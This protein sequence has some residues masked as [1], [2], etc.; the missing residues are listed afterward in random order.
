MADDGGCGRLG[1]ILSLAASLACGRAIETVRAAQLEG[2]TFVLKAV[3]AAT[4][5]FSVSD[6]HGNTSGVEQGLLFLF[7]DGRGR[8]ALTTRLNAP[9]GRPILSEARDSVRLVGAGA[10]TELAVWTEGTH[11]DT[12]IRL[13][14]RSLRVSAD[15]VRF[16]YPLYDVRA[17]VRDRT[18]VFVRIPGRCMPGA[19]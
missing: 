7:C 17:G 9:G 3:D 14:R 18:L 5:P 19:V 4:V 8:L 1:L 12:A 13:G 15:T 16:T 6:D 10:H 2:G 11:P